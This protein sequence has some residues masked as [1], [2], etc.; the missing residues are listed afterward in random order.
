MWKELEEWLKQNLTIQELKAKAKELGLPVKKQMT[1]NDVRRMIEKFLERVRLGDQPQTNVSSAG[2]AQVQTQVTER[3]T[4]IREDLNLP[5]TYNKDKLVAMP[6]NPYWIHLYWDFSEENR[7]FLS[8][9]NVRKL[10]LR[11]YDVTFIEFDGTNAHRTFEVPIDLSI[12]NYYLN[13]PMPGAHYLGEIGYYDAEG[14]YVSIIRSNLC[15]V[16][17]NSPSSSTRERWLDLRKHRRIVTPAAGM[18][19]PIIERVPGS[20]HGLEHLFRISNVGSISVFQLS[21]KGI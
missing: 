19:T 20:P 1:K 2:S 10:V 14:R 11:V 13:I 6:V 8:S 16:P 9:G 15:K 7:K 3:Q 12:K 17:T 21:G 4:P 5:E 18:L